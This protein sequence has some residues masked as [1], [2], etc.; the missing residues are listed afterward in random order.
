MGTFVSLNNHPYTGIFTGGSYGLFRLNTASNYTPSNPMSFVPAISFKFLRTN[1]SSANI[2]GT[3]SLEGSDSF[4]F[5]KHDLTNHAPALSTDASTTLHLLNTKF[6]TASAWPVFLGLSDFASYDENGNNIPNPV[7]PF[8]L[9]FQPQ[10][11]LKTMFPDSYET[12]LCDYA[13]TLP[14]RVLFNVYAEQVPLAEPLMIGQLVS[15]TST[16]T[17]DFADKYLFYEH[18][19]MENDFDYH[20]EWVSTAQQIIQ[21]QQS[22]P[23]FNGFPDLPDSNIVGLL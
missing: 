13:S 16:T 11:D 5:F 10:T 3:Y 21:K 8:R 12:D 15:T 19:L 1:T 2:F 23:W 7:F 18:G 20:P 6:E 4:N 9:V 22:L 17:S 14:P